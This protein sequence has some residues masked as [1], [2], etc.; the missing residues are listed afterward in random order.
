[1]KLKF[2]ILWLLLSS[3]ALAQTPRKKPLTAV[4]EFTIGAGVTKQEAQ[5]LNSKFQSSVIKTQKFEVLERGKM[6]EILKAQDF[7]M[8]DN[9]NSNECAVQVG[10][11]LASEKIIIGDIGKVGKTYSVSVSLV[12]VTTGKREKTEDEQFTGELD[13]LFIVLDRLA[14]KIAG[15]YIDPNAKPLLKRW[16][17]WAGVA[18]A[19]GGAA[20]VLMGGGKGSSGTAGFPSPPIPQ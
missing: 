1:M 20:A 7:M 11:L 8:S 12:D 4:L 9:C 17:F 13:G 10:Q 5:T 2:A 3:I 15:T 6:E 19:G 16:W 14:Q 18:A